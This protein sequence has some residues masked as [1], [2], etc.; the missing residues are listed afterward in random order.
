MTRILSP[1]VVGYLNNS[2][3]VQLHERFGFISDVLIKHGL[4]QAGWELRPPGHED[5][6]W[7]EVGFVFDFESVPNVIRGP[8]GENKRGGASHDPICRIGFIPGITKDIAADVYFEIMTYC[9]SIDTQRFATAK[10]PYL[11][12]HIIVPYVKTR[13]W[14]RRWIKSEIVRYWPSNYFLKYSPTATAREMFGIEGDQYVT[15]A[16][17]DVLIEKSTQ[18]TADIKEVQ[19]EQQADL[20]K[21]SKQVTSALKDAKAD[22]T[23]K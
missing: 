7:A 18:I 8:V 11:P 12:I 15:M 3:Y 2:N 4:R 14:S 21:E 22:V 20:V 17:L 5:E 23:S 19:V 16:K 13:D 1:L 9:D 10:H 6:I